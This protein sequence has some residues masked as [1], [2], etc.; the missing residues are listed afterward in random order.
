[1]FNRSTAIFCLILLFAV[2]QFG[3]VA[4]EISHLNHASEHSQPEQN[5]SAEQ[6]SFCISYANTDSGLTKSTFATLSLKTSFK[7]ATTQVSKTKLQLTSPYSV[8]A[9]PKTFIN[10]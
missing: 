2:T 9:P 7:F 4:H 10:S 5:T 8:R 6:C 1:M 3:V